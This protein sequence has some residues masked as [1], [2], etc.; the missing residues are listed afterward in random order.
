[1]TV[2]ASRV[3]LI[4]SACRLPA[5]RDLASFWSV[6]A[7]GR[8]VITE[9]DQRRFGTDRHRHPDRTRPGRAVTFA[10]GQIDEP[11]AFDPAFFGIS[12]R[13]A[14]VMDPQQRVLLEVAV[15]AL[16]NAGIAADSLAGTSV[17]V[18][19]GAS[20]L[21]YGTHAQLDTANIEPQSMTGNTLSIVANRLSYV[22]D[23]R[24]PSYVVDTAC[25]SSLIA[26]H[27]ALEDIRAGRIDTAIVGGVSMLMHPVPFIGFSRASML[28]ANGLCRAFDAGADGYVRSEGARR[29]ACGED[30]ARRTANSYATDLAS[31]HK[32]RRRTAGLSAPPME[33]QTPSPR[34]TAA[35][36]LDPERLA[37]VE[38]HARARA[39]G[40]GRAEAMAASSQ[41]PLDR[42]SIVG[43]CEDQFPP[44]RAGLRLV[45]VLKAQPSPQR[46]AALHTHTIRLITDAEPDM[47]LRP[48]QHRVAERGDPAPPR[49]TDMPPAGVNSIGFRQVPNPTCRADGDGSA[50]AAAPR[51]RAPRGQRREPRALSALASPQRRASRGRPADVA[52]YRQTQ[53]AH[54][55]Q[56]LAHRDG[57][58][59]G[60]RHRRDRR[61]SS[62]P[63]QCERRDHSHFGHT[64]GCGAVCVTRRSVP[65]LRLPMAEAAPKWC[66]HGSTRGGYQA[67][68]TI[69][70][71]LRTS[72]PTGT[73]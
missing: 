54:R 72:R 6:L 42:P 40:P 30:P 26:L 32:T 47:P 21:D 53:A 64:L 45:G 48:P 8:C 44:P 57:D 67:D 71:R 16:E 52:A 38:A 1:M 62:R 73:S 49:A 41:A 36:I 9:L 34:L 33:A 61:R 70:P 3:A 58:R 65:C 24:G 46:R 68:I 37:F 7:D 14:A 55:R 11:Y 13:E 63:A 12:P 28:S 17:G 22:L 39:S 2:A 56:R 59:L 51:A 27:Q 20:S 23:L 50:K 15:E 10:A 69:P 25:S 18:Y 35:P 19:V 29:P 60:Q 4:G 5:A 31:E 43:L 66:R